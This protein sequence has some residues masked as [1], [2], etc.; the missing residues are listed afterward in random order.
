MALSHD[1]LASDGPRI[2]PVT[3]RTH[4]LDVVRQVLNSFE[5]L[6]IELLVEILTTDTLPDCTLT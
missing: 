4:L 5:G 2:V 1:K 6:V 3:R